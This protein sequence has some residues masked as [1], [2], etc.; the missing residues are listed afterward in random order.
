[1]IKTVKQNLEK[2]EGKDK[3]EFLKG[4]EIAYETIL[5]SFAKEIELN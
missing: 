3:K 4:A 1:M 2:L 5:T